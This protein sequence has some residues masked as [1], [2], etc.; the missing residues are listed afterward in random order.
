MTV[1]KSTLD[2]AIELRRKYL[3][4]RRRPDVTPMEAEREQEEILAESA[5]TAKN[6]MTSEEDSINKLCEI[7]NCID[8][9]IHEGR[10]NWTIYEM[11]NLLGIKK[12][13]RNDKQ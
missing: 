3:T 8:G 7:L 9:A 2:K 6:A 11:L 1:I 13:N 4:Y 10:D 5:R 12:E